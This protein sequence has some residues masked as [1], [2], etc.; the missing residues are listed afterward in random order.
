MGGSPLG[1]P[2]VNTSLN[3]C[4][5]DITIPGRDYDAFYS[6]FLAD[7]GI[8]WYSSFLLVAW[9]IRNMTI[10][11]QMAVFAFVVGDFSSR[12]VA[13]GAKSSKGI[14]DVHKPSA[15]KEVDATSS[16]ERRM[17]EDCRR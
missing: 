13:S 2:S 5:K 1:I 16:Q 14:R 9:R 6:T 8:K 7:R 4:D 3:S 17:S 11:F 12:N 10:A 15:A